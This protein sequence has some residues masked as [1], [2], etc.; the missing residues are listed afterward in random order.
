MK[1][2][3]SIMKDKI[4]KLLLKF[5]EKHG[6]HFDSDDLEKFN[7]LW[8][9]FYEAVEDDDI[10]NKGGAHY[11]DF[12]I[13]PSQFINENNLQFAEGNV[14]KYVCRHKLKGK[15]EDIQKAKHYLDMI[16]SRDYD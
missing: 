9:Q 14:V 5:F 15:K 8:K 10:W 12:E 11:R 1:L 3:V 6:K 2:K 13:Q 16:L 4:S 7:E